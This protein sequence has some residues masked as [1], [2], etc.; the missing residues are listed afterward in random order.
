VQFD[1]LRSNS[2]REWKRIEANPEPIIF[3]GMATC[4]AAAG[5][6]DILQVLDARGV[7]AALVEVGCIGTC[8]AEPL[9]LRENAGAPH[10]VYGEMNA[11]KKWRIA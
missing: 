10:R 3:L 1:Q 6:E 5:A 11:G 4:G 2:S 8:Y 9:I 7:Q